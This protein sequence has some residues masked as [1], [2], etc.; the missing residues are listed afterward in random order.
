MDFH[1]THG[2]TVCPWY[3]T[4]LGNELERFNILPTEVIVHKNILVVD[5]NE[6]ILLGLAKALRHES[7]EVATADTGTMAL[8]KLSSCQYDLCL[9]DIHL[10]DF[11]G[12][13][14][15]KFIKDMCPSTKVI[16]MTASCFNSSYLSKNM[17]EAII[18][19]ACHFVAKP[20]SLGEITDV[21]KKTLEEGDDFH[22]SFRLTGSGFVKSRR[23]IIRKAI[24]AG[25][26]FSM[27]LIE[28]GETKR[29]AY[30]A[31]SVDLSEEGIGLMTDYPLKSSQIVGFGEELGNRSGVVVWSAMVNEQT[32]RAG[33]KF[34]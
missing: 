1:I 8:E 11:T 24:T 5:D 10:P 33:V 20:F 2:Q 7:F 27:T 9:L 25:V 29:M 15:M 32:Y 13:E 18:N 14:L 19:G 17:Q 12:L 28:E 34:A 4:C 23:K 22:A 26:T 21:V 30:Q 6:L 3:T 16:I 31:K